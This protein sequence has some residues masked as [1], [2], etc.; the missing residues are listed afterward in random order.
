MNRDEEVR[1]D[2]RARVINRAPVVG[3]IERAE[4]QPARQRPARG[5]GVG[6]FAGDGGPCAVDLLGAARAR[7]RL[8][9]MHAEP[10]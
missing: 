6:R 10:A 2:R 8:E 1:R 9:R 4:T 3:E 5:A 7:E